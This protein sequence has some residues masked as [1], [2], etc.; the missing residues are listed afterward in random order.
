M[1]LIKVRERLL[2]EPRRLTLWHRV[3]TLALRGWTSLARRRRVSALKMFCWS[4]HVEC[5]RELY[6]PSCGTGHGPFYNAERAR[7]YGDTPP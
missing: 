3:Q 1:L 2:V 4:C 7:A 5:T 6:C